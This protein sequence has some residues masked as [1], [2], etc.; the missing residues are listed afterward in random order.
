[1]HYFFAGLCFVICWALC[2]PYA[3]SIFQ[4]SVLLDCAQPM[5]LENPD[6]KRARNLFRAAGATIIPAP[7]D[8]RGLQ[9]EQAIA[10]LSV[11]KLIYLTPAHHYPTG[12]VL[13]LDRRL[14]LLT[15]AREHGV[16]IFEDDYDGDFR[17]S[18]KPLDRVSTMER[19]AGIGGPASWLPKWIQFLRLW[20]RFPLSVTMNSWELGKVQQTLSDVFVFPISQRIPRNRWRGSR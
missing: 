5:R 4:R 2:R 17:F 20:K 14:K 6:Y 9:V 3:T 13:A 10:T 18:T 12:T 8:E 11:P 16:T 15:W 7:V 19:M 1:M